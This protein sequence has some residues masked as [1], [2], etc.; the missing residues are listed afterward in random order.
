MLSNHPELTRNCPV[1]L[2]PPELQAV[3]SEFGVV[4]PQRTSSNH[5]AEGGIRPTGQFRVSSGWFDHTV[6]PAAQ[7]FEEVLCGRTT[8]NSLETYIY[9]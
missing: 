9:M 1:G 5:C 7:W 4:Q 2:I 3:S 8:P 6:R